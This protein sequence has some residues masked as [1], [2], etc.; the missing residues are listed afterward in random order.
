ML[1]HPFCRSDQVGFPAAVLAHGAGADE[2][3]ARRDADAVEVIALA[4]DD[5]TGDMRAMIVRRGVLRG[6]VAVHKV[7]VLA[8]PRVFQRVYIVICAAVDDTD[9][10]AGAVHAELIPH[11]IGMHLQNAPLNIALIRLIDGV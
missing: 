10:R 7:L 1:Q 3:R 8:A 4:A 11:L 2:F 6:V 9:G 5:R